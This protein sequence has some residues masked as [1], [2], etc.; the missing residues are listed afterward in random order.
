MILPYFLTLYSF[1][2]LGNKNIFK[3]IIYLLRK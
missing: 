3:H 1:Y 2:D